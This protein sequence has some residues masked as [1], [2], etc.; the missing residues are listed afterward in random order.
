MTK[1]LFLFGI[2]S[3]LVA[4]ILGAL[5]A[6]Y[7]K[8]LL[9]EDQMNS[10]QTA[11]RYQWYHSIAILIVCVMNKNNDRMLNWIGNVFAFGIVLFSGS[12]YLL[13]LKDYL[14]YE[15]LSF[16]GPITPI[17][18]FVLITGWALFAFVVSKNM[19]KTN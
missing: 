17:G 4:V 15:Q 8:D 9:T 11:N 6:H 14:N 7:L 3:C 13:A 12:I 2:I 10:L 19:L 5:G 16:L 18:G 1:K